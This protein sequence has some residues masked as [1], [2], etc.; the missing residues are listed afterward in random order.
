MRPE[1]GALAGVA[2]TALVLAGAG[3]GYRQSAIRVGVL[4]DCAGFF[5]DAAARDYSLAAAELPL[6]ERGARLA[7]KKPS[8][9]VVGAEIGGRRVELVF[10]CSEWSVLRNLVEQTRWLVE[11]Q[12]ASIVIGPTW[13]ATEGLILRTVARRYPGV[14]FLPGV[15]PAQETTLRDPAPNLF[16]FGPDGVQ[17]SAGLGSYA[18]HR[19]GWR[20]AAVLAFDYSSAWPQAAGFIA[21]FCALGGRVERVETPSFGT[22]PTP[23]IPAGVDGVA[24][25][26]QSMQETLTFAA[27]NGGHGPEL[28][29]R[30]VL[31]PGAFDFA[32]PKAF[33]SDGRLLRGVVAAS[34]APRE[35]GAPA[36]QRFRSA[37]G[38]AFPGLVLPGSA[39]GFPFGLAY[40]DAMA[41]VAKAL[42]AVR[43]NLSGGEPP[44]RTALAKVRPDS[45]QGPIRLVP[46]RQAIVDAYLSRVD[47]DSRGQVALHTLRVVRN[48]EQTFGGYFGPSTP[49]LTKSTP[50]CKRRTPPS[51]A[52]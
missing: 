36:W 39:A 50:A 47:V 40:Y 38:R 24:L 45:P 34:A 1:L 30:L 26:S 19:L 12:R 44:L 15:S 48:V 10:A 31:G 43:G 41:A 22:G 46:N 18:Y 16:R 33:A 17:T 51:W 2:G 32:D 6:L 21:E 4:A 8:D 27:A 37:Y 42:E 25:M 14:A 29:K 7:S 52:R 20:R 9:G 13:G 5:G 28:A 35:V 3:C 11:K 49:T 23:A